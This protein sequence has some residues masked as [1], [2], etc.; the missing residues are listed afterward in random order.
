[1]HGAGHCTLW[2]KLHRWHDET[3]PGRLRW[4]VIIEMQAK[5]QNPEVIH[6]CLPVTLFQKDNQRVKN[7][8]ENNNRKS[9]KAHS[10]QNKSFDLFW[11]FF[12]LFHYL[13]VFL[14]LFYQ[15]VFMSHL[16]FRSWILFRNFHWKI[17]YKDVTLD[18]PVQEGKNKYIFLLYLFDLGYLYHLWPWV[19]SKTWYDCIQRAKGSYSNWILKN[20]VIGHLH[21]SDPVSGFYESS[22]RWPDFLSLFRHLQTFFHLLAPPLSCHNGPGLGPG[23]CPAASISITN[24]M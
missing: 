5:L 11:V 9:T 3:S 4:L 7:N 13:G 18:C 8:N 6:F 10:L 19:F 1:M 2:H 23:R 17:Q 14:H 12:V 22:P 15:A 24:R 20:V 21:S 16:I